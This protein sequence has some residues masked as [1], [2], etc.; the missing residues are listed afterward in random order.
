MAIL[1]PIL[2]NIL[3][4]YLITKAEKKIEL[5]AISTNINRHMEKGIYKI[6]VVPLNLLKKSI[7]DKPNTKENIS[8]A[9]VII[10]KKLLTEIRK[11][12]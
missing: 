11:N 5:L 6:E 3:G 2:E 8:K 9:R 7:K 12:L 1:E 4:V 10:N